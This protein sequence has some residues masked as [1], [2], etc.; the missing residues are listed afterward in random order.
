M[1]AD[2]AEAT[3]MGALA[4]NEREYKESPLRYRQADSPG[5]CP[6]SPV[7]AAAESKMPP[8]P[9]ESER[10]SSSSA[11][12]YGR[13]FPSG[14]SLKSSLALPNRSGHLGEAESSTGNP[15]LV[16]IR[17]EVGESEKRLTERLI[18]VERRIEQFRESFY[19]TF[20]EKLNEAKQWHPEYDRRLAQMEGGVEG[21]NEELSSLD[22]KLRNLEPRVAESAR[23]KIDEVCSVKLE[24]LERHFQEHAMLHT[25]RVKRLQTAFDELTGYTGR[26]ATLEAQVEANSEQH[27]EL[28]KLTHNDWASLSSGVATNGKPHQGQESLGMGP[29]PL[30]EPRA[31][32]P[33]SLDP[34]DK[35]IHELPVAPK[36]LVADAHKGASGSA[37]ISELLRS[38]RMAAEAADMIEKAVRESDRLA[39]HMRQAQ[40]Q[41]EEQKARV[42]NLNERLSV[43][44][45]QMRSLL[46]C[47][48]SSTTD[49]DGRPV[50]VQS[51]SLAENGYQR[52]ELLQGS[53]SLQAAPDRGLRAE[54][55]E[56][57][58]KIDRHRAAIEEMKQ[59]MDEK[60]WAKVKELER[61]LRGAHLRKPMWSTSQCFEL[62]KESEVPK[63]LDH[64]KELVD[65]NGKSPSFEE[66]V[67]MLNA[68]EFPC[69]EG[70]CI[71]H[72][73]SGKAY[74]VL[75]KSDMR[76]EAMKL[77]GFK[78][79]KLTLDLT[80]FSDVKATP[81]F[82]DKPP[83][84]AGKKQNSKA[85]PGS[86][87][88]GC[89]PVRR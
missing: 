43:Q 15:L 10:S 65:H 36:E 32:G 26:L 18:R 79:K 52:S 81:A 57:A 47:S 34:L 11:M 62:C 49:I 74:Y 73:D 8:S 29:S 24:E 22:R 45:S 31:L 80:R 16:A 63:Y 84:L 13:M 76:E 38:E 87:C 71:L 75:Y 40:L 35:A 85:A 86:F 23:Q 14:V 30:T 77:L 66:A 48:A 2:S 56:I 61:S 53:M 82:K 39:S 83:S 9:R 68:C 89:L 69:E 4:D 88:G 20:N 21:V 54:V 3:L 59:V 41:A 12:T 70:Y 67:R 17:R 55:D 25:D 37:P 44:E 58:Y 1:M 60:I 72:C 46:A 5:K 42:L 51:E 64:T 33:D 28:R 19:A 50:G 78:E 27:E 7:P 6:A